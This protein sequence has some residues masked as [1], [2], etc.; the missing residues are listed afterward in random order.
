MSVES[1]TLKTL[2]YAVVFAMIF[3][4]IGAV[5]GFWYGLYWALEYERTTGYSGGNAPLVFILTAPAGAIIGFFFGAWLAVRS[6]KHQDKQQQN[7]C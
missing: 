7:D 2:A 3:G 6:G 5:G 4:V 1:T